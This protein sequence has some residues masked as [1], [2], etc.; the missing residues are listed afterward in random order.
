MYEAA[1]KKAG[2]EAKEASRRAA[3]IRTRQC[4]DVR[5]QQAVVMNGVYGWMSKKRAAAERT[6]LDTGRD[7]GGLA[8]SWG[9]R[10]RWTSSMREKK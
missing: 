9:E 6:R 3:T 7:T 10:Q 8:G 4:R 2:Y 1:R 5:K